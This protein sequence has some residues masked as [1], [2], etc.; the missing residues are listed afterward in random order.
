M[1]ESNSHLVLERPEKSLQLDFRGV[2]ADFLA[3]R[4]L[5]LLGR[6][7]LLEQHQH[8]PMVRLEIVVVR[9]VVV[10]RLLGASL[11]VVRVMLAAAGVRL[12]HGGRVM[13]AAG[14]GRALRVALVESAEML[15]MVIAVGVSLND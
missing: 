5:D 7:L 9:V 4:A 6:L 1:F 13:A 15:E 3:G 11:L 10:R 12:E 8:R 14:V 2:S